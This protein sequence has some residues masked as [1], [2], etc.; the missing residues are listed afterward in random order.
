MSEKPILNNST[1]SLTIFYTFSLGFVA[2]LSISG[3]IIVQG[4]LSQQQKNLEVV[5]L[6]EERQ[7]LCQEVIKFVALLK[8][9]PET[10][11][12]PQQLQKLQQLVIDWKDSGEELAI[13]TQKTPGLSPTQTVALQDK[14]AKIKPAGVKFREAAAKI[15]SEGRRSRGARLSGTSSVTQLLAEEQILMQG[16]EDVSNWYTQETIAG[17]NRLKQV[18]YGLLGIILLVLLLEGILVFRPAVNKIQD[19]LGKL[20][21]EQAQSE[22]LLLNIL[23]HPIA[24]RLKQSQPSKK[25]KTDN[26]MIADG[27]NDA[28]VMFADIVGFTNLSS[29]IPPQELVDLLNQ[30]F[31][32][33]DLIAESYKLEK[34]KTI[35]DA[36]MVV[37]GL[38]NPRTDHAAAI[39][40][41]AID[42][43]DAIAQFNLDTGEEFQIR[44]GINSGAV[45]AGVIGIKK[46]TYD[47]WGDTVNIASRME[48]HGIPGRIHVTEATYKLLKDN[49]LFEERGV[50]S[51]KGKGEMQTYWLK[52]KNNSAAPVS[53]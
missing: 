28:T 17:V 21:L 41:M 36:Y 48:S 3:Q 37:G 15:V 52:G 47:L 30:I 11:N 35:G 45:V 10:R 7:T 6:I 23:P 32:R 42:M 2:C 20:A 4:M 51:I 5:S 13:A 44:I 19:T 9:E 50:T 22:N 27:Y 1:R 14:L 12:N 29:R 26:I 43:L 31:S 16:L 25:T 34:I 18:E 33:F 8:L 40:S 46:F 24:Q 38:P 39:A 53:D 49:F